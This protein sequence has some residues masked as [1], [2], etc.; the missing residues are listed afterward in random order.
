MET[1]EKVR[2]SNQFESEDI[3]NGQEL[4][5]LMG[6]NWNLSVCPSNAILGGYLANFV[7][8]YVQRKEKPL[9]NY[10]LFDMWNTEAI[11]IELYSNDSEKSKAAMNANANIKG[12]KRMETPDVSNIN[13]IGDSDDDEEEDID[14]TM[15]D[16]Q[17]QAM[18]MKRQQSESSNKEKTNKT[19]FNPFDEAIVLSD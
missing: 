8:F 14:I 1:L 18:E 12:M 6:S 15:Q 11:E 9:N 10:L 2:K 19:G 5:N 4:L 3:E 7:M 13:L 16:K 17:K